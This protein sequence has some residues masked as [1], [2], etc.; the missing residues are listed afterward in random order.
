[1]SPPSIYTYDHTLS[2]HDAL[3]IYRV[4]TV[5]K[6]AGAMTCFRPDRVTTSSK[7]APAMMCYR[8]GRATTCSRVAAATMSSAADRATTG[9]TEAPARSEEHTSE[10]QSLMRISYAVFCLK[11]NNMYGMLNVH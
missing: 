3:P 7:A 1:M 9:S 4:T 5:L 2:L 6:A 11:K 10:L 8:A